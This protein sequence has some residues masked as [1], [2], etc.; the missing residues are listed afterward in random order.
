VLQQQL[1]KIGIALDLRSFEFATFYSDV[2]KGA[3]Q[4]YS[5]RW[6]GGN[7]NPDIF[8]YVFASASV[9]PKGANRGRYSNPRVDELIDAA[10]AAPDDA[11]RRADYVQLQQLLATDLPAINLWYRDNVAVMNKRIEGYKPSASGDY[12]FLET[13]RI[14]PQQ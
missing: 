11:A 6:I 4:M 5:L 3:F 1:R 10:N 7:E 14:S 2:V 8:R 12:Q 9:P 13:V